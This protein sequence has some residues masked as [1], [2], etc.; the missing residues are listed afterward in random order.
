ML[1]KNQLQ[2]TIDDYNENDEIQTDEIIER[3]LLLSKLNL[4]EKQIDEG[5]CYTQEEVEIEIKKWEEE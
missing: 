5:K 3:I 1:R 4:S 2:S